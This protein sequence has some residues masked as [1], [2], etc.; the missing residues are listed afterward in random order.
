MEILGL[1]GDQLLILAGVGVVLLA[2]LL[3]LTVALK[4]TKNLLK[5]GCAGIVIL[6]A[7]AIVVLRALG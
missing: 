4:L 2:V 6:L 5:L 3:V 7:I 1:S